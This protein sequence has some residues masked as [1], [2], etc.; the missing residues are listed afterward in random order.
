MRRPCHLAVFPVLDWSLDVLVDPRMVPLCVPCGSE[1]LNFVTLPAK[2]GFLSDCERTS[3]EAVPSIGVHVRARLTQAQRG[4]SGVSLGN[5]RKTN[6][7]GV[8]TFS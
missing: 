1:S 3:P 8:S 5:L 4:R 7:Y 2:E 6:R